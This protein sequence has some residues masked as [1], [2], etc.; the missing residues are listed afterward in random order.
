MEAALALEGFSI[1]L[2]ADRGDV[3]ALRGGR[4]PGRCE[5][6]SAARGDAARLGTVFATELG[7]P[8]G[9]DRVAARRL[10]DRRQSGVESRPRPRHALARRT[11]ADLLPERVLEAS[12]SIQLRRSRSHWGRSLGVAAIRVPPRHPRGAQVLIL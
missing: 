6:P 10:R 4:F 5:Q 7:L 11:G 1:P 8:P 3:P 2:V 12:T 9:L